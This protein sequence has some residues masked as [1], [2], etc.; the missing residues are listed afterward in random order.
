MI[1]N[2]KNKNIETPV[3]KV[4]ELGKTIG[5]MFKKKTTENLLFEFSE[6]TSL[7]I[8]SYFVFFDFLAIWLDKKNRVLEWKIIK[9]FTLSVKPKKS[10]FKL[11]EIPFN[12]KN[13]KIIKFF[14]GE[15]KI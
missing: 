11:I 6:K 3:K 8:H 10:F 9:S 2:F 7:R 4:S 14:V 5:L 13:G 15:R 12:K 1:I